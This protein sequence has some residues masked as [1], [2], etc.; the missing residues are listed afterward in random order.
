MTDKT[1]IRQ[2]I[3]SIKMLQK[4][5]TQQIINDEG[6]NTEKIVKGF[7]RNYF[8]SFICLQYLFIRISKLS[9]SLAYFDAVFNANLIS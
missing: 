7:L 8:A 4:I 1:S 3:P 2:E 5:L 9:D 6:V